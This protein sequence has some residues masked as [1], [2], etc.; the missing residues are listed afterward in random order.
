MEL[1][2]LFLHLTLFILKFGFCSAGTYLRVT[3]NSQTILFFPPHKRK[4]LRKI[5]AIHYV[6]CKR[7]GFK[8]CFV[9]TFWFQEEPVFSYAVKVLEAYKQETQKH[10]YKYL[11]GGWGGRHFPPLCSPSKLNMNICLALWDT[12][13]LI[14]LQCSKLWPV[15][16]PYTSTQVCYSSGSKKKHHFMICSYE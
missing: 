16:L 14:L 12:A 7:N 3:I 5:S 6:T 2:A 1:D 15:L 8:S 9:T 11:G 13:L 4:I 10:D